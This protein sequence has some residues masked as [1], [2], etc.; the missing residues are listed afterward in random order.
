M[1]LVGT[2]ERASDGKCHNSA[3]LLGPDGIR[4]VYRR[5]H[6]IHLG[7]DRFLTPG[8]SLTGPFETPLGRLGILICY[9]LR[10][11]EPA[12]ALALQG[13]QVILLP[14]ARPVAATLDRDHVARTRASEYGVFLLAADHVGEEEESA[15]LGRSLDSPGLHA[16][17]RRLN[18]C[19]ARSPIT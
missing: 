15:Y 12:R 1:A 2:I 11:P 16:A 4:A 10:F 3:V 8:E 9:D 7:V 18:S 19:H 17:H 13:A 6:L 14:T 5:I